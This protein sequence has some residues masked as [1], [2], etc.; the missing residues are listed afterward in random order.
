MKKIYHLVAV[1]AVVLS[2]VSCDQVSYKKTKSGLAYKIFPAAGNDSLIKVGDVVKFHYTVKYNDS[3]MDR[4]NTYGKLPGYFRAQKL[5]KPTYDFLE[6]LT[7]LKK[8]DSV[9]TVQTSDTL[10]K[11]QS[12]VLPPNAKKGDRVTM[13]VKITDVFTSDSIA[14]ADFGKESEKDRP[15]Q[16][17]Q[18]IEE[19]KQRRM[20]EEEEMEKSG[21]ATK[22][23]AEMEAYLKERNIP[24]QK[25]GK[26][27][28]VLIKEPGTGPACDSGKYVTV[29][30]TGRTLDKDSVFESSVYPLHYGVNPVIAGWEEGLKLFHEGGKGTLYVPGFRA[31]GKRH[32]KFKP[33]EALIFDIEILNVSDT[34]QPT[35]T[36]TMPKRR[37]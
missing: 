22:G 5:E 33:Y 10:M 17:A 3:M 19:Q 37:N 8:G 11:I 1:V 34:L 14:Q 27:T 32:P 4:F 18:M 12:P 26:G 16:E 35:A 15:R 30:Y 20:Q 6:L 28:F 13:T 24:A 31:Y 36:Q 21:E 29:K 9:V 2:I 23:V 7:Q 25:T